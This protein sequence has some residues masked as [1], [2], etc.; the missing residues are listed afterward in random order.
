[1][2]GGQLAAIMSEGERVLGAGG[3]RFLGSSLAESAET[4]AGGPAGR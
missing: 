3:A 1:M 4:S 2:E